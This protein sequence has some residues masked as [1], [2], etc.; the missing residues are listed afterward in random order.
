M[1]KMMIMMMGQ[2]LGIQRLTSW[3]TFHQGREGTDM[4]STPVPQTGADP[5][6]G[7]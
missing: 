1:I 6:N 4:S 7:T 2:S 3:K 5:N